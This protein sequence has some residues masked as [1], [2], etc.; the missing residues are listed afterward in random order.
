MKRIALDKA[1]E[2]L[3]LA[4]GAIAEMQLSNGF[5][6]YEQAWSHFLIQA[7]R[8]YSKL[9]QGAKGCAKSTPWFGLKKHERKKDPLLSYI[10]HARNSDEHGIEYIS[11]LTAETVSASV[12]QEKGFM[13]Q[14]RFMV[15]S[16]GRFHYRNIKA[17]SGDG[18]DLP[19][20]ILNPKIVP[21]TVHDTLHG[22][23]FD[24]PQMHLSMPIVDPSPQGL[25]ILAANYL[26]KLLDEAS[27]LPQRF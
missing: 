9:E 8:I 23:N 7:G 21:L 3:S 14:M 10:H 25:A 2:H 22:D 5:E 12:N 20:S 13:F 4:K 24:P 6:A 18:N 11:S 16:E 15:D 17:K 1:R 19:V 27:Q 26:T